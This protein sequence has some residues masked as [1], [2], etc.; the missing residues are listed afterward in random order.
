MNYGHIPYLD[1]PISRIVM[2]STVFWR[3]KR[4]PVDAESVLDAYVEAGGNCFDLAA[5]YGTS[6]AFGQWLRRYGDRERIVVFTKG[7]HHGPGNR[8]RV[9]RQDLRDDV[10]KELDALGIDRL[11]LFVLHR[12]D[13]SVPVG[14]IVDWLNEVKEEGL[15]TAFGG[16]NWTHH[17][18][19]AANEYALAHGRQGLS[20]SSPNLSLATTNEPMWWEALTIDEEGRRWH[21]QTRFPLF[22]WS[23][24]GGGWFSGED[25]DDIRR[26]YDNE[27]NR[28]R[29]DRLR[30]M[31]AEK[32]LS[33]TQLA[34]AYTLSQPMEI[35]ALVGMASR[36]EVAEACAVAGMT[37]APTE[38]EW[39]EH[40]EKT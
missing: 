36:S 3:A 11:D 29:R 34:L 33:P 35:W 38:L 26:V 20:L 8:R 40:G 17:R 37:L 5:V 28:R 39:L 21:E 23:S 1:K 22:S 18:I 16:S 30:Q 13:P 4:G 24:V 25:N 9:T 12:D 10:Q 15:V 31:A 32:G 6:G 2:G 19:R 27:I 14:E 7:C